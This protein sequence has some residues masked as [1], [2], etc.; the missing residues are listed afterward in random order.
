MHICEDVIIY[1]IPAVSKQSPKSAFLKRQHRVFF[2][3][4]QDK[5]VKILSVINMFLT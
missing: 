3:L 2:I 1:F 5:V 4:K